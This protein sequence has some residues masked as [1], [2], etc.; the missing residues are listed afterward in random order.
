MSNE[1]LLFILSHVVAKKSEKKSEVNVK[2]P[3]KPKKKA[4]EK[5]AKV[6]R[7]KKEKRKNQCEISN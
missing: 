1:S 2:K 6:K 4:K 7:P 3:Q 5:K